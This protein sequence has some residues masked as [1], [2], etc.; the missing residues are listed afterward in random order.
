MAAVLLTACGC[1]KGVTVGDNKEIVPCCDEIIAEKVEDSGKETSQCLEKPPALKLTLVAG[2][3]ESPLF[4]VSPAGDPERLFVVEQTGAVKLI[5][6]GVTLAQSFL[7]IS[8][9][10]ACCGERG[11]LGLA[12]HPDYLKNGRFWV[13]YTD[14]KGDT[15]VA[16][17]RKK[18][19]DP[20]R[21]EPD[22]VKILFTV[23]QPYANHNGG[24]IAFGPDGYL[25]VGMG[26]GG[27]GGD[28]LGNG[29]NLQTKLGKI[30]RVDVDKYPEPP[31]GN[32]KGGDPQIW[33]Y[34]WRNPWRFSFDRATG[35]IYI[36]DV[37]QNE[38]E[39]IDVQ[40]AGSGGGN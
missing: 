6:N 12:F 22:A 5:K 24:M 20:E 9:L 14:K 17:Y 34:G 15:V 28:P 7:D 26:D 38:W 31:P 30:L 2:G 29:Q 16:E 21:A 27:S 25:Y 39:E 19:G 13:N 18:S 3:F 40:P 33:S 8:G 11:L 23:K 35:D 1:P 37:G 4:A 36:A 32:M 10:A